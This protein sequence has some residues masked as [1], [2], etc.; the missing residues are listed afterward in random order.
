MQQRLC[1]SCRIHCPRPCPSQLAFTSRP[2]D[3]IMLPGAQI[4]KPFGE[5]KRKTRHFE[6]FK[7]PAI[8]CSTRIFTSHTPHLLLDSRQS[9]N[10]L[11]FSSLH[12]IPND[13][14]IHPITFNTT[15]Q[16]NTTTQPT[17]T[18][19]PSWRL[20]TQH[21]RRSLSPETT[22]TENGSAVRVSQSTSTP[23]PPPLTSSDP[24]RHHKA[25]WSV[26]TAS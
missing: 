1:V 7:S 23:C 8:L 22:P 6:G 21:H 20:Q 3:A 17:S 19:P 18:L 26:E 16:H 4:H 2:L 11:L 9:N 15:Q 14:K 5:R 10:L 12:L 13:T 24:G 25:T